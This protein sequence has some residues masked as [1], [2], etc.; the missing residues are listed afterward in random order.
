MHILA[1]LPLV[2]CLGTALSS[3]A[4]AFQQSPAQA[5]QAATYVFDVPA[6]TLAASLHAVSKTTGVDIAFDPAIVGQRNAPGLHGTFSLERALTQ[7]LAGSSLRYSYSSDNAIVI[8]PA[9]PPASP[10]ATSASST[11]AVTT[12]LQAITVTGNLRSESLAD[13][14]GSITA[15]T[16]H[17]LS[18]M[19]A[20]SMQDYLQTI[21][22]V[23]FGAMFPGFSNITI[24]GIGTTTATDQGQQTTGLYIDGIPLTEPYFNLATPDLDIF[25]IDRVEVLKGP[26]GTAFGTGA[27][28]GAINYI[29]NKPDL[30]TFENSFQA[31]LSHVNG[32]GSLGHIA[33]GMLN[34]PVGDK[35][36][37]RIVVTDRRAPGYIDNVGTGVR[38]SNTTD[39]LGSRIL[40]TWQINDTTSLDWMTLYQRIKDADQPYT[41]APLGVLQK[42][43]AFPEF[44]NTSIVI[45]ALDFKHA[46]GWGDLMVRASTH[47]K[48]Q[49]SA[50][51]ATLSTA[52]LFDDLV[53]PISF[54]QDASADG[55]TLEARLT[56][57]TGGTIEWLVGAI[58]DNT[59]I[60]YDDYGFAPGAAA[61]IDTVYGAGLGSE[62]APDDHFYYAPLS[63]HGKQTAVYTQ[64]SWTFRPRWKLT[65]GGRYY[66]TTV[67]SN[68][69]DAGLF[70]Y[71]S[72]GST[73][74]SY[75]VGSQKATGFSPMGSLSYDLSPNSMVYGLISTG[76]RYGGPNDNPATGTSSTPGSFG[77]DKL[78][79]YEAGWRA[80]NAAKTFRSD[81]SVYFIDWKD[82]QLR[83]FTPIGLAYAVNADKAYSYGIDTSFDWLVTPHLQWRGA[84]GM[85]LAKLVGAFEQSADM[86]AP[87]GTPL[88]GSSKWQASSE[89]IYTFEGSH[90]PFVS[91]LF[92]YRSKAAFDLFDQVPKMG[93]Y[94]IFNI[95]AGA[96]FGGATYTFYIDNVANKRGVANGFVISPT[97]IQRFYLTPRT[98]GILVDFQL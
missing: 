18:Q 42:D 12:T 70:N 27:M 26:Q 91:G 7:L 58:Y 29:T 35:V 1:K 20:N 85:N 62:L 78:T 81:V 56:S 79:N 3:P 50:S 86:V 52:S 64:V 40:A 87:S 34:I 92:Q 77:P 61:A 54:P 43:T 69:I 41:T 63:V 94:S 5:R 95:R 28:G 14:A 25:D 57:N 10:S 47:N 49:H 75:L 17:D 24:R 37:F 46:F 96:V 48:I 39:V 76:F 23:S 30:K 16:G 8:M 82:I 44:F 32:N 83:T 15:L 2:I 73:T 22:G 6:Q 80:S 4:F 9:T 36:A 13:F 97:D 89:L 68:S 71:L 59:H 31:G 11:N 65:L 53:S 90:H 38:N 98:I 55:R 21:P 74:P 93:N 88:P 19:G 60:F 84:L 67:T 33:N 45:N 66:D 51:D 72:T